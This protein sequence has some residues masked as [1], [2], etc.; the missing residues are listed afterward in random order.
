MKDVQDAEQA[1]STAL[2]REHPA[3]QNMKFIRF[4]LFLWVVLA[5]LDSD[6]AY[7]NQCGSG[8]TTLI[9]SLPYPSKSVR[10]SVSVSWTYVLDNLYVSSILI[11][12]QK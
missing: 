10:V 7:Q 6:A 1:Y 8:S 3:V 11:H 2:N 12:E 4:L 5:L 9:A